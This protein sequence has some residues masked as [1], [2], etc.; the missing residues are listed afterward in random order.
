MRRFLT[1][2]V[3]L[4]LAASVAACGGSSQSSSTPTS[5]SRGAG[6]TSVATTAPDAANFDGQVIDNPWFPLV[7]G[8]TW[9][10]RGVK[11]GEP[12]REIMIATSK[13]KMIQGVP[14]TVV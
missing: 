5:G 6:T 7:P 14:A 1:L 13:T 9:A 2:A 8:M 12:A 4:G 3:A 11:D 10:Y